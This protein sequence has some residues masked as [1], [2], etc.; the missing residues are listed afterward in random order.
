MESCLSFAAFFTTDEGNGLQNGDG[1]RES[2]AQ[3]GKGLV[4]IDL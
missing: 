4:F 3:D 1:V 2:D